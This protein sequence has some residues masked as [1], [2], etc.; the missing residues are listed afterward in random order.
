M[1]KRTATDQLQSRAKRTLTPQQAYFKAAEKTIDDALTGFECKLNKLAAELLPR[2]WYTF[3]IDEGELLLVSQ[4]DDVPEDA[5]DVFNEL[6]EDNGLQGHLVDAAS[7]CGFGD[8]FREM[9]MKGGLCIH[10]KVRVTYTAV[11]IT[12]TTLNINWETFMP[13]LHDWSEEGADETLAMF[14]PAT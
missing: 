10:V 2:G 6:C 3:K 1:S 4:T 13:I 8:A 11:K 7:D 14:C 5:V 9:T 12:S